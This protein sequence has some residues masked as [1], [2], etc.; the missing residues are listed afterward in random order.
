MNWFKHNLAGLLCLN[1]LFVGFELEVHA[2]EA[3]IL[4]RVVSLAPSITET[5]FALGFGERLVGVTN[6][7]DYPPEA[8]KIPKIGDFVSPNI[9]A[10]M[11][12]TPDVVIGVAGA[13]DPQKAKEM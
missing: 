13:T 3:A 12:K 8:L 11:A 2:T 4:K 7:C 1:F 5:L 10:I 9:E 6:Y